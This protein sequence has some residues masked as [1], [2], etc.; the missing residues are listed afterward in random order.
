MDLIK[1]D[2]TD[3]WAVAGDVVA[4]DTAKIRAGWGVEVVPRQW[5]NWFE[6][7]QDNNIAYMLQK[8]FPEWDATTQYIINKSYVQRNGIVYKATATSTNSDPVALTSWVK[9][10]VDSTPYLEKIKGLPV[11]N[12]TVPFIDAGGNAV[13]NPIGAMGSSMLS[14][15]TA[16]DARNLISAQQS[17]TNLTALSGVTA[18]TNGLPYFTSSTAMAV[19]AFTAFGRSIVAA[20]DAPAVRTL[21]QLGTG[22]IS[23]VTTS[24]YDTTAGALLKVGDFGLGQTTASPLADANAAVANGFYTINSATANIPASTG[25]GGTL[26]NTVWDANTRQ[27]IVMQNGRMWQRQ[28]GDSTGWGAWIESW[29][30]SNLVKTAS[31]SDITPGRMLKVGDFGIGD[32]GIL[33]GNLDALQNNG[34]GFYRLTNP[35]S[36]SPVA[37][38][39]CTVIHQAYDNERTQIATVEGNNS[40]RTFI[41]KYSGSAWGAWVEL[42]HSGNSSALVSQVQTGIQPQLDA[43]V[44]KS[45]DTMTGTLNVAQIEVG[46]G[47]NTG[48]IDMHG[49][50]S[51][52]DYDVRLITDSNTATTGAGRLIISASNTYINNTLTVTGSAAF[53]SALSTSGLLTAAGAQINGN[54]T[55]TGTVTTTTG[56]INGVLTV[57]GT[58]NLAG[59]SAGGMVLNSGVLNIYPSGNTNAGN[60]HV[61]F[62]NIDGSTRGI[63]YAQNGGTLTLAAN[64]GTVGMNIFAGGNS[65]VNALTTSTISASGR[66]TGT[67]CV[68]SGNVY[69]G[70]GNSFLA[71]DGNVYGGAWG[72]YLSTYLGNNMITPGNMRGN[73]A[74]IRAGELGSYALLQHPGGA[75]IGP[76][77]SVAGT[78]MSWSTCAGAFDERV[79]YGTWV[80]MGRISTGNKPVATTLCMRY[81]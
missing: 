80:V 8:G 40:V 31:Y 57:N 39:P 51:T 79:G 38:V 81:A 76:N 60:G 18:S 24:R 4:P 45:G 77:G 66:I 42:Y 78:D 50:N 64:G 59:G 47:A 33:V 17:N 30:T 56:Q 1:Y 49:P 28:G 74:S 9:A 75:N 2:M 5:W 36:G 7:R 12:A 20:A 19:A 41:R 55:V 3:I 58:A 27:Q 43:K 13:L 16:A 23:N 37:G 65:A 6:N 61:W 68:F 25:A 48:F 72:G 52:T 10:F 46:I 22:A 63:I 35:L 21:L 73:L 32:Q 11:V 67:D 14:T 15:G 69:A 44:S 62:R 54:A 26:I 29:T 34:T 70:S 53:Q 71:T